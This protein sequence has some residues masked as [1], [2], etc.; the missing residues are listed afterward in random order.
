MRFPEPVLDELARLAA[1]IHPTDH[2]EFIRDAIS[3]LQQ[4]PEPGLGTVNKIVRELLATHLYRIDVAAG[5]GR[6]RVGPHHGYPARGRHG[7]KP[8][9]DAT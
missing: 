9:D 7:K 3:C 6:P 5:V 1:P 2:D 4:E 8:T